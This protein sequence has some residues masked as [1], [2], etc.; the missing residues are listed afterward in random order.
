MIHRNYTFYH[1]NKKVLVVLDN[2]LI[3]VETAPEKTQKKNTGKKKIEEYL[4]PVIVD[5]IQELMEM[6]AS[7]AAKHLVSVT[8]TLEYYGN[9]SVRVTSVASMKF[10]FAFMATFCTNGGDDVVGYSMC[11]VVDDYKKGE[12]RSKAR[13]RFLAGMD[14]LENGNSGKIY[15]VKGVITGEGINKIA[16]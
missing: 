5:N 15:N 7:K 8:K 12:G 4:P 14:V 13:K 9:S 10:S 3:R 2:G 16:V 1:V 6:V 11:S